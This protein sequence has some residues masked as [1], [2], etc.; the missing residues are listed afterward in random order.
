MPGA[1][2]IFTNE[3]GTDIINDMISSAHIGV[4]DAD[5][6]TGEHEI[7]ETIEVM[8]ADTGKSLGKRKPRGPAAGT[9]HSKWKN[10]EDECLIDSWKAVSLDPITGANQNPRQVLCKDSR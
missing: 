4:G 2:R 6:D 10:L 5:V 9:H 1:H 3:E 7:E 8:D